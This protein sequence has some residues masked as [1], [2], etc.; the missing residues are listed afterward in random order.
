MRGGETWEATLF[1]VAGI[2]NASRPTPMLT[3]PIGRP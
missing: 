2:G 3:T 1:D